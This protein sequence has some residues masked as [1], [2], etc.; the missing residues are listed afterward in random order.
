MDGV[1]VREGGRAA[2]RWDGWS[3]GREKRETWVR[4]KR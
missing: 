3:C 2:V 1:A 4:E